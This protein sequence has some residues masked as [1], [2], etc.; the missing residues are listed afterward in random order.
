MTTAVT[1]ASSKYIENCQADLTTKA[2]LE[3]LHAAIVALGTASSHT[4][5]K[6]GNDAPKSFG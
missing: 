4:L 5:T 2:V 1:L 6:D 3:Y